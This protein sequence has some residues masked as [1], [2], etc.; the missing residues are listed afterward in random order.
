MARLHKDILLSM[1]ADACL[2]VLVLCLYACVLRLHSR[3]EALELAVDM[4][5]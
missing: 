5:R 4:L 3:L 2:L 1:I